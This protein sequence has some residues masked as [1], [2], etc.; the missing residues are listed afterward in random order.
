MK[1]VFLCL[2]VSEKIRIF[3]SSNMNNT[4]RYEHQ[5]YHRKTIS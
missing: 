3:A 1:N 4:L 2:A 5:S